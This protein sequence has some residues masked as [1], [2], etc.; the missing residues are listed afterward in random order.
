MTVSK[1]ALKFMTFALKIRN[2]PQQMYLKRASTYTTCSTLS[3]EF[4]PGSPSRSKKDPFE[5]GPD[6]P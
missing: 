5:I 6:E 3:S 2:R 1:L 4:I